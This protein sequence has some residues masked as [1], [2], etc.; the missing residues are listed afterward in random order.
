MYHDSQLLEE[1]A[2]PDLVC[3]GLVSDVE[4]APNSLAL[5]RVGLCFTAKV[6]EPL[7]RFNLLNALIY[8]KPAFLCWDGS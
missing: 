8:S 2:Q 3:T 5:A 4:G 6:S 7:M 1:F